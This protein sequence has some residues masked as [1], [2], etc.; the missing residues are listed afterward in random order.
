M[1]VTYTCIQCHHTERSELTRD[2]RELRCR[3]CGQALQIPQGAWVEDRLERCLACPSTD[4]FLRK[5]FPQRLGVLIV[6]LGFVASSIAWG[7]YHQ[8][9]TFAILFAV[10]LIDLVL[11]LFV[12][13]ALM[14]YRCGAMY[15]GVPGQESF[16]HFDL[17]THEKHRQLVARL[18]QQGAAP[19][20]PVAPAGSSRS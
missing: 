11:Y 4:L 13:E 19:D 16:G 18:Q 8:Y 7:L 17:S 10:A 12:G 15:R 20:V 9:L 5:D 3:S 6:V 14:C 2:T 1:N